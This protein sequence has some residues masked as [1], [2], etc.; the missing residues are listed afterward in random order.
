MCASGTSGP[1][2]CNLLIFCVAC[3]ARSTHRDRVSVRID[4]VVCVVTFG[5]PLIAF[6]G[7]HQFH[8][9]YPEG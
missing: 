5:F 8:L 2:V 3:K 6:E 1:L 9:N 4:N 7:M